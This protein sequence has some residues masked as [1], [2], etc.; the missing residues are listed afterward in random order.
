MSVQVLFDITWRVAQVY[1]K[2]KIRR[3]GFVDFVA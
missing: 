2:V 3:R 1:G